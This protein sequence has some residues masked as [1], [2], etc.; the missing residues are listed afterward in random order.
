[1]DFVP[2]VPCRPF[3]VRPQAGGDVAAVWCSAATR[4]CCLQEDCRG[5]E[6]AKQRQGPCGASSRPQ[7]KGSTMRKPRRIKAS[8]VIPRDGWS[9]TCCHNTFPGQ[10]QSNH[11][12]AHITPAP[13][14][15]LIN[16]GSGCIDHEPTVPQPAVRGQ[17]SRRSEL[18]VLSG[19]I[20]QSPGE[21]MHWWCR[22]LRW[23]VAVARAPSPQGEQWWQSSRREQ[24][25]NSIAPASVRYH[26][27]R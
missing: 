3:N 9:R 25:C 5:G 17:R 23:D 14:A 11:S 15:L 21:A 24:L 6:H 20:D 10:E 27:S 4:G 1:M 18:R 8:T 7:N 19:V 13:P 16:L 12:E 22:T 2:S 26:T